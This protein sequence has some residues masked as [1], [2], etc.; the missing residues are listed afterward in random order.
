MDTQRIFFN[1]HSVAG[2]AQSDYAAGILIYNL[3]DV[4]RTLS[5]H[6]KDSGRDFAPTTSKTTWERALVVTAERQVRFY[7]SICLRRGV[8]DQAVRNTLLGL[9]RRVPFSEELLVG[10]EGHRCERHHDTEAVVLSGSSIAAAAA[11]QGWVVSLRDCDEY[12]RGALVVSF[13]PADGD[14]YDV[15]LP[16]FIE[17]DDIS[18]VKRYYEHNPKHK[19][20]ATH[21]NGVDISSM[22]LHENIAQQVLTQAVEITG[23]TRLFG[24]HSETI[25][26]FF[27]HTERHYHGYRV[28]DPGEYQARD[29]RVFNGLRDLGWVKR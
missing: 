11:L 26:V 17:G 28:D 29:A 2:Q 16:H 3:A 27:E 12:R 4:L 13:R 23:E 6:V 19:L 25:Y 5:R 15:K 18:Q 14:A 8:E 20:N 22:D 9:L 7:D 1:E 21:N 10:H 24:W